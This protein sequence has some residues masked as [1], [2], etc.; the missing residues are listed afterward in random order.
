[1]G[2]GWF[3]QGWLRRPAPASDHSPYLVPK[4]R[5][6]KGVTPRVHGVHTDKWAL[7][8]YIRLAPKVRYTHHT[9]WCSK[10]LMYEY[11][12]VFVCVCAC[13][14]A[15]ARVCVCV[16]VYARARVC[17]CVCVFARAC[18]CVCVCACACACMYVCV[19]VCVILLCKLSLKYLKN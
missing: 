4:L 1:M 5:M 14:R 11:I 16:R 13:V 10:R 18:V 7:H 8:S 12:N 2:I 19:C 15:R 9:F 3:L 6:T 17:F